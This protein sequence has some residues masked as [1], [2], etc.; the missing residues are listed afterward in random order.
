MKTIYFEVPILS[1][2]AYKTLVYSRPYKT[3]IRLCNCHQQDC[4]G[5]FL[6]KV[7][8][9]MTVCPDE[10]VRTGQIINISEYYKC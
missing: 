8:S 2:R 3:E 1:N 4:K 10:A 9:T 5:R 7:S 6:V